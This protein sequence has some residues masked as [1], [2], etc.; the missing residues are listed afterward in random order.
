MPVKSLKVK[1]AGIWIPT[2][3]S[4]Y[5]KIII[6][7]DN[8]VDYTVADTYGGAEAN[9]YLISA[10]ME[11]KVTDGI[12]SF[13]LTLANDGG[14]YMNK[15]DGGELVRFYA[16]TTDATTCI[17]GGKIDD[18]SYGVDTGNGF[19]VSISGRVYPEFID[20]RVTATFAAAGGDDAIGNIIYNNFSGVVFTFWNGSAWSTATYDSGTETV[21]WDPAASNFPSD[22]VNLSFQDK[23]GWSSIAEICGQ[24]GLECYIDYDDSTSDWI[25]RTFISGGITNANAGIAY[26]INLLRLSGYGRDTSE[27]YNKVKVFGK[28][29]SDNI[30]LLKT[31][32][33]SASQTDLWIKDKVINDSNLTTM[34][35]VQ[36][37]A[38]YELS[39]GIATTKSGRA[40]IIGI[41]TLRPGDTVSCSI[42]YS[43]VDQ[44]VTIKSFSH[45]FSDTFTTSVELSKKI[46]KIGD[47]F[48][49]KV[50][51][52]DF[53]SGG[54]NLNDMKGSYTVFFDEST[55]VMTHTD[56]NNVEL[57][58]KLQLASD[59]TYGESISDT[60]TADDDVTE[61]E[62]RRYENYSTDDDTYYVSN[63]GGLTWEQYQAETGATHTFAVPGKQLKF[64]MIL[65][66]DATT[67][68]SPAYESVCMLYK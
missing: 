8:S 49:P 30:I 44:T 68:P 65:R 24:L 1:S 56:D 42:P 31:E 27:A 21:S 26:G 19:T 10:T 25:L 60:Y 13:R 64:K 11:R 20:K 57:N 62:F 3:Y 38:N 4:T 35:E 32:E 52:D 39:E 50:N 5:Y 29:E 18:V 54:T 53:L 43:N 51:P 63:N 47:L 16:D 37:K 22:T 48:L 12:C 66:R 55:S 7:D 36:D 58:G 34:D 9:N 23:K 15:F 45:K 6:T 28:T 67:D 40:E 17:F 33:N 2:T 41:S 14:R 59:A 61:C 46:K